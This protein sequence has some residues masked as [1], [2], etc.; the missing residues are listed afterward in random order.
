MR[1]A[2]LLIVTLASSGALAADAPKNP[3]LEKAQ[4]AL[5]AKKYADALKSLEA[6]EKK[7]GLDLDSYST[8]LESKAL[9]LASTKKLDKA[10]E[11]F[12]KLLSLDPRRD[13]A[14]KY[15]GDVVKALEAA[16]DWVKKNGGLQ[17]AA[18][19]PVS[20]KGKVKQVSVSL[21][22]DPLKLAKSARIHVKQADGTWKPTDVAFTNG[23]AAADTDVAEVEYWA[24]VQDASKDQLM[25]L[26]S[27]IRPQKATAPAVVAE[28]P[29]PVEKPVE[30]P[31]AKPAEKV[32][33]AEAPV[34][35]EEP[36]LTPK[37]HTEDGSITEESPKSG[38]MLRPV[39]YAVLGAAILTA[40][41]GVYFGASSAGARSQIL[42]D[43][44][45]MT[46]SQQALYDRDQAAIGQAKVANGLFIT[47]AIV[48]VIGVVMFVFGG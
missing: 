14:G 3:D 31:A 25:F 44:M 15:K 8:L 24:E 35:E 39:S 43:K 34:K 7:G 33:A 19:D 18:L 16:L 40:G 13:L 4:K 2:L 45:S 5:G 29:K 42:V 38:S 28:A 46:V 48:A 23:V 21:K 11:E 9:C 12:R 17:V 47:A 37:E 30:K 36:K 41:V 6:A 27:A 22:N 26:G 32:A 20:E 10:E 1:T